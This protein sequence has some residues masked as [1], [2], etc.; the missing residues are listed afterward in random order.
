MWNTCVLILSPPKRSAAVVISLDHIDA[1]LQMLGCDI[2][3]RK[4][5]FYSTL[6]L[7]LGG[8]PRP[9]GPVPKQRKQNS[10]LPISFFFFFKK[11]KKSPLPFTPRPSSQS[12]PPPPGSAPFR[13]GR[14]SPPLPPSF[15]RKIDSQSKIYLIYRESR[16]ISLPP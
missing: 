12:R 3:E 2:E 7:I 6:L 16:A 9:C 15:P 10:Q 1:R 13:S 14:P 5:V 8:S 11:K 4:E